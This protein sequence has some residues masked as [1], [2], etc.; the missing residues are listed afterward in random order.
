[1]TFLPQA[2]VPDLARALTAHP[3]PHGRIDGDT[4]TFI[5]FDTTQ[6]TS[7][8]NYSEP[9][10]GDPCHPLARGAH[11]PAIAFAWQQG[12]DSPHTGTGRGR[13]WVARA[14]DYTGSLSTTR[15]DAVAFSCKDAGQDA[16]EEAPTLR[17]MGH[18]QSHPNGG[19]Q[20]AVVPPGASVRRLTPTE[21]ER[22]QSFPDGWSCLCGAAPYSTWDCRCPDGP[23]Y[24]ALGNA[25]TVN[26]VEWV[27]RRLLA[28]R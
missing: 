19:G 3:G 21:C 8:K 14:G 1:M 4:E 11:P 13:S 9:K 12:D 18:D 16:G 7:D 20:V 5:P 25:V 26:V 15:H 28:A 6:I 17:R 23:R 27:G 10:P 24:A 22:L 2:A